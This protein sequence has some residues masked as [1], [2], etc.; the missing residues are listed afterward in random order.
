MNPNLLK[1]LA[2][3]VKQGSIS[4]AAEQLYITQPTL[5]RAIQQLESRV[6]APVLKRTRHGMVP[7]EVG[8]RLARIGE[9]ILAETEHGEE[10]IRQWHSGF[11]N[12]FTVGIDPMWEYA[13]YAEMTDQL[14]AQNR[15]VFHLRAGSA[16]AQIRL[17]K[18]GEL[19]FLLAPAHITSEQGGLEREILFRDRSAVF[20]GKHSDLVG[21][22]GPVPVSTLENQN[23]MIAGAKAGFLWG[24]AQSAA[25]RAAR[26]A[27]TGAIRSVLHLL[28]TTDMLV[29]LPARL[30][31]MTGQVSPE[32][33]ITVED[34]EGPRRDIALWS[35][36]EDL[37][38]P[39]SLKVRTF[40]RD[41]MLALDQT[42]PGYELDI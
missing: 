23:W 30:T 28:E 36:D 20:A 21:C 35:R 25:P 2:M 38:R 31:L 33:M 24:Q 37:E 15:F 29:R 19:D 41:W 17:L 10:I 27:F 12:Q 13:A 42:L 5:T 1:Q 7:T 34:Q 9:R 18:Q 8:T 16:S 4:A 39:D 6:G 22:T 26:I 40:L 32:Q 11:D 14:L 3:V